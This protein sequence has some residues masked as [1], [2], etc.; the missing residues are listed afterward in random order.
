[1]DQL[2]TDAGQMVERITD[3][4]IK[5]KDLNL[6]T[7]EYVCLKVIALL[8]GEGEKILPVSPFQGLKRAPKINAKYVSKYQNTW[9]I[10]KN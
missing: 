6:K 10:K 2:R 1:M 9:G 5:Y 7:E 3:V 8:Q 4:I